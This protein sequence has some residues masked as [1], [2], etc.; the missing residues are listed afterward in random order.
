MRG[1][2][3][4]WARF[5]STWRRL[6][7]PRAITELMLRASFDVDL[8]APWHIANK[9]P[10]GTIP[11]CER[12][13][14]IC[15]AGIENVVSLRLIDIAVFIDLGRTDLM[16]KRKPNF[17]ERMLR[18]K[19]RLREL[20]ASEL[21]RALP[22]LKQ[23]G[24]RRIC[25]A[26]AP[27]LRCSLHPHWPTSCERFPYTLSAVRR[28]VT[29]GTRCPSKQVGEEHEDR[30]DQLFGASIDAYNERIRDAVLLAHARK[31]LDRIGVGT[32]ITDPKEDAFEPRS[33]GPL[34]IVD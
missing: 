31:D 9:I 2:E 4:L 11:D 19:P 1:L 29:W 10:R 12:C 6:L 26:L 23:V 22:V 7:S 13:E 16:A 21:W 25:V 30:G 24:E 34:P 20:V 18:T 32:W 17:P 3:E 8:L 15:C 28:N 33:P 27:D 14:D 5:D